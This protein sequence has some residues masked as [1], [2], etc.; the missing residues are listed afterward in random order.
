ML[1]VS[2]IKMLNFAKHIIWK[3]HAESTY[4][5]LK[6][7]CERYKY[8]MQTFSYST[9][10]DTIVDDIDLLDFSRVKALREKLLYCDY[11]DQYKLKTTYMKRYS[12]LKINEDIARKKRFQTLTHNSV[13]SVLLNEKNN[14]EDNDNHL[15]KVN[16]D[17]EVDANA[18]KNVRRVHM[19]YAST[20]QYS[21]VDISLNDSKSHQNISD[22]SFDKN[23]LSLNEK[24]KN[25]Y[26]KYLDAKEATFG[27]EEN[28]ILKDYIQEF[29]TNEFC[30]TD[31]SNV[32]PNW[33]VDVEEF[34]DTLEE[35]IWLKNYGTPDPNSNISLVSCGGCGAAL[36]CKD[37]AIPGYL[38]SELFHGKNERKLRLMICQRC[39]FL[40]YYKTALEVKVSPDEYINLLKIIK[41]KKCAVILMVDL[42][43]F[44]CSIW[45]E[46]NSVLNPRTAVFVVGNK[47][48]L[49][50]QD[51][52]DFFMHIQRCLSKAVQE[53]T[54]IDQNSIR[55]VGLISAKTGYGIEQLINKLHKIWQYKGIYINLI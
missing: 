5:H 34:D 19:P 36:H 44:P 16:I 33:M 7:Y 2:N 28:V 3:N 55:Y 24:Y 4:C 21:N 52:K 9:R 47:I 26:N 20:D 38:P 45:P 13:Y 18:E 6:T 41:T 40:K 50:P 14:N 32:P 48:D 49:L 15:S 43:D 51:S 37:P 11:L 42:T 53:N 10:Q 27:K 8:L 46:I 30:K 35:K 23:T 54:G 31:F 39:H 17:T 25:L 1:S 29:N 12:Q 22:N